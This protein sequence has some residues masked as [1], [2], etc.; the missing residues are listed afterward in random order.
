M[1]SAV[2]LTKNEETNI[3]DCLETLSWCDEMIIIDDNSTDKTKEI[4]G[5]LGAKV[6]EHPLNNDFSAQRNFGLEKAI[7]EWVLFVDV[8]ERVTPELRKEILQAVAGRHEGY[9]LKRKDFLFGKWLRFG[10]TA[11]I[12]LLRLAKR[13]AG[14]WIRPVHEIWQIKGK[15]GELKNPLSHYPHQTMKEFLEDVN[16]YTTLNAK[17]FYKEG[18]RVSWWQIIAYPVG[19]FIKNY[20]LK[21]GFLDGIVGFLHAIFMSFHSF[22]TRAKLWFL[23]QKNA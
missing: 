20:F 21:L 7:G 18:V 16:F 15:V 3:K 19:K 12:K 8:D 6:F 11:S 17:V 22:L 23:W 13:E 14:R 4:A 5:K 1:V 9:F 10:E 2:V